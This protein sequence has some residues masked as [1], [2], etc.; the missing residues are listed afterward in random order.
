MGRQIE[1]HALPEDMDALLT[2]VRQRD[3]VVVTLR[4]AQSPDVDP[5]QDPTN[6]DAAMILWN[7]ALLPSLRRKLVERS[8]G[9]N[10]FRV[11]DSL[12]ILELIPSHATTWNNAPALLQGR[13]YGCVFDGNP[14]EFE[15]WYSAVARWVHSHFM[16]SP[17]TVPSGHIGPA[18]I[19]WFRQG[20]ILLP[21]FDPPLTAEWLSV[22]ES[23]RKAR[24]SLIPR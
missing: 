18:A 7:T 17:L 2:F 8:Q 6:E 15:R 10:Y 19:D 24:T 20:G 22:V 14:P 16:R 1:I 13:V 12:P 11:D 4:D 9:G 23:E 21:S 3:P 5:V